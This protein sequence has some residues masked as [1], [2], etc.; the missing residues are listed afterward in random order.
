MG[1]APVTI[2]GPV[3]RVAVVPRVPVLATPRLTLGQL[4]LR[5]AAWYLEHFSIPEIVHGTGFPAPADLEAAT[6]E[7]REYVVDL[8]ERRAGIRWAIVSTDGER[9]IGTAGFYRWVDEP[10]PTAEL[11]Y[12]LHPAWWGRGLMREALGAILHFGFATMRLARVE[13]FVV[14]DNARSART[15]ERLGFTREARLETHG[16]DEHGSPVDEFRYALEAPAYWAASAPTTGE[17]PG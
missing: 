16:T 11:G 2:P 5:D 9:P 4:G 6:E 3:D 10:V 12:D 17:P 15:L 8:F 14:T 1:S 13:A 7:L